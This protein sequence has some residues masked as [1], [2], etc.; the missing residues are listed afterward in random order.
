LGALDYQ[1]RAI[2]TAYR[3][4]HYVA[5][6][7]VGLVLP[8]RSNPRTLNVFDHVKRAQFDDIS[9]AVTTDDARLPWACRLV[10]TKY[11]LI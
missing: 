4:P 10:R 2:S 3:V 7:L 6:N 5:D 8:T 9:Q 11:H 1:V